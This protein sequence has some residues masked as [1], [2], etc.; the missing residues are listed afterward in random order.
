MHFLILIIFLASCAS[1]GQ[2]AANVTNKSTQRIPQQQNYYQQ[3]QQY[4]YAPQAPN[5]RAYVD[6]YDIAPAQKFPQDNDQEY[7]IPNEYY[8]R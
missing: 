2:K 5:S 3:N 8:T 4:Y 6:P 1:Q 7:R